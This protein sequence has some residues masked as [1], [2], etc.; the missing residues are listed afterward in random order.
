MG[1]TIGAVTAGAAVWAVLWLG[2]NAGLAAA[3]P[4]IVVLGQPLTHVGVLLFLI[5]FGGVALSLL[6]GFV[7][8]A[9][10]RTDV[11]GAVWALAAL[12]LALGLFFEISNWSLMPLWYH[13]VFL[14]C[15]VPMTVA[16][17]R[18][19]AGSP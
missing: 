15:I 6:A 14:A 3:L 18:W 9:V 4:E 1:R 16:G 8:A 12:Q 10:K 7:T 5:A 11:M 2:G 13:L 19:R 17:G